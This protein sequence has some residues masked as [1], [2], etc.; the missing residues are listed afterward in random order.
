MFSTELEVKLNLLSLIPVHYYI[1]IQSLSN[2]NI[3][4]AID[5]S[6]T[7]HGTVKIKG[8]TSISS[9]FTDSELLH[10]L[11]TFWLLLI[12]SCLFLYEENILKRTA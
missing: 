6:E 10:F 2:Q 1:K 4:Y 3:K 5:R 9:S 8:F 7:F 12:F 11:V